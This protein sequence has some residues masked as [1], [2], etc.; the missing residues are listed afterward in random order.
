MAH[1]MEEPSVPLLFKPNVFTTSISRNGEFLLDSAANVHVTKNHHLLIDYVPMPTDISGVAPAYSPGRGTM[2]LYTRLEKFKYKLIL[3]NVW[4]IPSSPANLVSLGRLEEAG[5]Y[6]NHKNHQLQHEDRVIAHTPKVNGCYPIELVEGPKIAAHLTCVTEDLYLWPEDYEPPTSGGD[7]YTATEK[8]GL[9]STWHGRLAHLNAIELRKYLKR[10]NIKFIEDMDGPHYHCEPCE[11]GKA[12]KVYNRISVPK[13]DVPWEII[14]TDLVGPITPL[15]FMREKYF[16]TFTCETTRETET[17]TARDKSEWL[18]RLK[19]VY[20]RARTLTGKDRP[21]KAIRTDY[22]TELRSLD[23]DEW[24]LQQG[25]VFEPS[26]PYSQEENGMAERT[27]GTL[28]TMA[29]VMMIA[30][31]IPDEL[32]PEIIL[33]ATQV[34][35][36]RPSRVIN[37]LSPLEKWSGKTPRI[38]HLRLIQTSQ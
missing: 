26:A 29:R 2:I 19:V 23:S 17:W 28:M 31:S 14:H 10:L 25:I 27:G 16:F 11:L 34:K 24:L 38:D 6:W 22:G 5:C 7:V 3:L 33:T 37:G 36:L 15:G 1:R 30:G 32:W 18:S 20:E 12:K 35:N 4:Y 21:V 9:L 8:P 13:T